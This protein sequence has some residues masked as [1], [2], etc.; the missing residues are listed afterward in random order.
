MFHACQTKIAVVL[1]ISALNKLTARADAP[2]VIVRTLRNVTCMEVNLDV[3]VECC[4]QGNIVNVESVIATNTLHAST[5]GE[6][7]MTNAFVCSR[8]IKAGI[9]RMQCVKSSEMVLVHL[10]Q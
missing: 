5:V 6:R 4:I 10:S 1:A 9:R 3:T 2:D 8:R 7:Y